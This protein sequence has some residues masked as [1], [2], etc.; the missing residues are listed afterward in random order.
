[1]F[2][3][4][5]LKKVEKSSEEER[6]KY[7]ER[8]HKIIHEF[9]Q[10]EKK[11]KHNVI[12]VEKSFSFKFGDIDLPLI[13]GTFDRLEKDP[14]GGVVIKEFKTNMSKDIL[15]NIF[16]LLFYGMAYDHMTGIRATLVLQSLKSGESKTFIPTSKDFDNLKSFI[17]T[18]VK[19]IRTGY[20]HARPS[21]HCHNCNFRNVCPSAK[22]IRK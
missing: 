8:T 13:I 11:E 16:Q 21:L 10:R 7:Y 15:F 17:A 6:V 18:I 9:L 14:L 20:I 5:F 12:S 3:N 1:M 4:E 2:S 22:L 19:D